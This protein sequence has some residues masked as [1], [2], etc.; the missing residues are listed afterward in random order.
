MFYKPLFKLVIFILFSVK[1]FVK[2]FCFTPAKPHLSGF[3]ALNQLIRQSTKFNLCR[4]I[5]LPEYGFHMQST[6]YAFW[7]G[8]CQIADRLVC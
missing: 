6:P 7:A 5:L 8:F 4:N 1:H 2:H 3:A